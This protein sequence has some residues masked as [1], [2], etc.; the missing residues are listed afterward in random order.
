[1]KKNEKKWLTFYHNNKEYYITSNIID[2]STYYLFRSEDN[3]QLGQS[4]N[5]RKLEEKVY[6]GK[7]K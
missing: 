5:P 2:R 1:M 6:E 7:Y 3:K 4:S